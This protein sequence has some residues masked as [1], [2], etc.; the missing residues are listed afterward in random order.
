[1]DERGATE[2]GGRVPAGKAVLA[3]PVFVVGALHRR[4]GLDGVDRRHRGGKAAAPLRDAF[5]AFFIGSHAQG[6]GRH[7]DLGQVTDAFLTRLPK[8]QPRET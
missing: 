6:I 7:D 4:G 5:A 8:R 3:V 1:M 2:R